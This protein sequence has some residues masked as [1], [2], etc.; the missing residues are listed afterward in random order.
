M[1][2]ALGN[3]ASQGGQKDRWTIVLPISPAARAGRGAAEGPTA[4]EDGP[5]PL[6]RLIQIVRSNDYL[7]DELGRLRDRLACARAYLTQPGC[8][9]VLGRANLDWLRAKRAGLLAQLRANRLEAC[10][11]LNLP[12]QALP[13][14]GR[15][16]RYA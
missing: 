12:D 13:G 11:L 9:L 8:N 16:D 14:P 15:S 3:C 1:A 6:E 4:D 5:N 10:Q 7:L 2:G